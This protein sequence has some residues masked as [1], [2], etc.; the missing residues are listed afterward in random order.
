MKDRLS[1]LPE[2]TQIP[3]AHAVRLN[4]WALVAVATAVLSRILLRDSA[5]L[6]GSLRVTVALL[7][8]LPAALYLRSLSKWIHRLD[9]MQ[10]RLQL[11]AVCVACVGMLL[12][13]LAADLLRTSSVLPKLNFGW[14]GY[15]VVTFLLYAIS[16]ASA[17]RRLR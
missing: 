4:L 16:L 3:I 9:E 7:P 15:F 12:V 8:L 14:E 10:R 11:E 1:L 5:G 17:N 13:T 6:S 2:A